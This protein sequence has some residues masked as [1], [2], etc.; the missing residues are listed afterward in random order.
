MITGD[1]RPKRKPGAVRVDSAAFKV[2]IQAAVPTVPAKAALLPAPP[3]SSVT[4]RR[5]GVRGA[6]GGSGHQPNHRDVGGPP[7][8]LGLGTEVGPDG[9]ERG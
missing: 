3:P 2:E 8:R 9:E 5:R 6:G 4:R 7:G 1:A